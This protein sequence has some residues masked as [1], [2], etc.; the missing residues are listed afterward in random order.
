MSDTPQPLNE[1][2]A[3]L[4]RQ[5][6]QRHAAEVQALVA[7]AFRVDRVDPQAFTLDSDTLTYVPKAQPE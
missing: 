2:S 3:L 5:E 6:V 1:A 4:L 7:M